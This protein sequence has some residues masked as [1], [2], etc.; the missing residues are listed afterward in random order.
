MKMPRSGIRLEETA[1]PLCNS[2]MPRDTIQEQRRLALRERLIVG[3]QAGADHDQALAEQWR[4]LEEAVWREHVAPLEEKE[5]YSSH[6][7]EEMSGR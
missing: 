3:Y 6:S 5:G 2:R 4:P 1:S 7:G